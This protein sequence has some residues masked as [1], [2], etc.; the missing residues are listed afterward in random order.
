MNWRCVTGADLSRVDT[1]ADDIRKD[2]R[3]AINDHVEKLRSFDSSFGEEGGDG[4]KSDCMEAL[5][6]IAELCREEGTPGEANR[7]AVREVCVSLYG[8]PGI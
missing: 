1:S 3:A 8:G 4:P 7:M 5:S 2:A 6:S